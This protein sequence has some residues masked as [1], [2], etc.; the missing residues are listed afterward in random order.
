[1]Y[2]DFYEIF[3]FKHRVDRGMWV[4]SIQITAGKTYIFWNG[5][6]QNGITNMDEITYGGSGEVNT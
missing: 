6:V 4:P 3:K 2:F 5:H 1:M